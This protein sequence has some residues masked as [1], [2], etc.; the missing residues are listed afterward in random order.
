MFSQITTKVACYKALM[1]VLLATRWKDWKT[2][3]RHRVRLASNHY[4]MNSSAL[5]N[6]QSQPKWPWSKNLSCKTAWVL[7]KMA[8]LLY[9]SNRVSHR[10]SLI[11]SSQWLSLT[12]ILIPKGRGKTV[13]FS[14]EKS[15]WQTYPKSKITN[16]PQMQK[17]KYCSRVPNENQQSSPVTVEKPKSKSK[18]KS[19]R[20]LKS[21]A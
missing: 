2:Q 10:I 7:A 15:L 19:T 5:L 18:G 11:G 21:Q 16:Q 13:V 9:K 6:R 1:I 17:I 20:C 3:W 8:T 14:M 4:W 12:K